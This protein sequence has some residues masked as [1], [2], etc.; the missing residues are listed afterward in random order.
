MGLLRSLQ[1]VT[2]PNIFAAGDVATMINHPRE[3]AGVFA[4]S[5]PTTGA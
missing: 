1:T 5:R 4:A 2:D 3:K